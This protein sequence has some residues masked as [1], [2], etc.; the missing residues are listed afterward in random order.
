MLKPGTYK[1]LHD[2]VNPAPD[3][4]HT[5]D[6]RRVPT[7]K[8]GTEF[9]VV[10][11]RDRGGLDEDFLKTLSEEAQAKL[12]AATVYTVIQLVGYRWSHHAIGPG[13]DEQYRALEEAL[14]PVEESHEAFFTRLGV[15]DGFACWL[16][17]S[18]KMTRE[19]FEA[20]HAEYWRSE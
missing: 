20:L 8:E 15:Q 11:H 18:G 14:A 17:T 12:R 16:V 6:W 2:V 10:E 9:L 7:W 13:H 1:L 5:R 19:Q 3:R 4:R